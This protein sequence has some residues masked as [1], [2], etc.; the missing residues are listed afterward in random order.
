MCADF[1]TGMMEWVQHFSLLQ[2]TWHSTLNTPT[3]LKDMH[4]YHPLFNPRSMKIPSKPCSDMYVHL[5]VCHANGVSSL[6][7][8]ALQYLLL[9]EI[10]PCLEMNSSLRHIY[11]AKQFIGS[12]C[13]DTLID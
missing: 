8:T 6:L 10:M 2:R 11:L 3:L 5:F 12:H 13:L 9:A 7:S 1:T 4:L